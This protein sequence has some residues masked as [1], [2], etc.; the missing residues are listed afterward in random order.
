MANLTV[1]KGREADIAR[2]VEIYEDF[3]DYEAEH[4]TKTNWIKGV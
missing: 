1:R 2:I 4:G 3:L